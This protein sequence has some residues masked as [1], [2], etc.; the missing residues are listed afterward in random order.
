MGA[1]P[2]TP[3]NKSTSN[4]ET[5]KIQTPSSSKDSFLLPPG[6]EIKEYKTEKNKWKVYV[7]P[8]GKTYRSLSEIKKTHNYDVEKLKEV[9]EYVATQWHPEDPTNLSRINS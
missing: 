1:T 2:K 7:G 6:F 5:P 4:I 8:D 9:I 3:S